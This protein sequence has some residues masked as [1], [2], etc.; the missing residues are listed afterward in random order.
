MR[1]AR[2]FLLLLVAAW[3]MACTPARREVRG[4]IV[5]R[6][7]FDGN[8][9]VFS[10]HNDYQLVTQMESEESAFGVMT[11]PI[12]PFI[13]P[14][15][16]QRER[17]VRDAYRLEVWYAHHGWL[18]AR[19]AGW[20]VHRVREATERRAG[21]VDIQ[22]VVE[23]G[24]RSTV[25]SLSIDGLSLTGRLLA[26]A[27][28]QGSAVE[29]GAPF[30]LALAE[31]L[32]AGLQQQLQQGGFA[33]ATV[34]L[35]MDAH[36]EAEAVDLLYR[37]SPGIPAKFGPI[38]IVGTDRVPERYVRDALNLHEGDPY[39]LDKLSLAQSRVFGLDTFSLV[40][41]RPDLSDPTVEHVPITV[42]VTEARF[43]TFRVGGGLKV[44]NANWEPRVSASFRHTNLFR[45]L[46]QFRGQTTVGVSGY[47]PLVEGGSAPTPVWRI[48]GAVLYPRFLHPN[49]SQQVEV[50]VVRD[51]DQSFVEYFSPEADLRTI[52]KPSDAVL[53][54]FG[55]HIEIFS[56]PK[57]Q[58]DPDALARARIA[59]GDDFEE[60][61]RLTSLDVGFT[62]DWRDDRFSSRRGSFFNTNLRYAFPLSAGDFTFFAFNGDWRLF[63]PVKVGDR[64][65][66]TWATRVHGKAVLPLGG[67]GVPYPELSFLGG[68]S[69]MRGYPTRGLGP[70]RTFVIQGDNRFVPIGGTLGVVLSQELRYHTGGF[71]YAVFGDLAS[72]SNPNRSVD[73]GPVTP[74][75]EGFTEGL[76]VAAGLGVRYDS[77]IGPLR[78]DFAIRPYGPDD[79]GPVSDPDNCLG[80]GDQQRRRDIVR[81]FD[82]DSQL[83]GMML[84]FAFGEAI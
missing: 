63:R 77:S 52:F 24:P 9:R 50:K 45:R 13:E 48:G 26:T 42:T 19:F 37:A 75:V 76:R 65:P 8:G 69:D 35:E 14:K 80:S 15:L 2:A 6:I 32:R 66:I 40:T 28:L 10:G 61:Y 46:V 27:A 34:E 74:L 49:L 18:D 43:R 36:P 68:A 16:L 54:Q 33:Y 64:V 44:E 60:R 30:D 51:L 71:T 7:A 73:G 70:Y 17:L 53:L 83:P 67:S 79:C 5:R 82:R 47:T 59:Y 22:G 72:L 21:V 25:R 39:R 4:D 12:S 81:T 38:T 29:E 56:Y 58:E 55:P 3:A 1:G 62:L 11:W 31:Q 41:V 57:L 20:A 84:F 23:P 78:V